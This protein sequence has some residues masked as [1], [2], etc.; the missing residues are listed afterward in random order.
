MNRISPHIRAFFFP[1]LFMVAYLFFW[2]APKIHLDDPWYE[3]YHQV[4]LA[5]TTQ[6]P[7][8][9]RKLLDRGGGALKELCGKYPYHAR[10][11]YLLG[12]YYDDAGNYDS[13]IVHAREAIRLGSG[14]TVD[15]VDG[16]ATELLIS[17]MSEK[18]SLNRN[19]PTARK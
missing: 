12:C 15:Q 6:D 13:A 19:E 4:N 1:S 18:A 11:H 14:A 2:N 5:M 16:L 10:V 7:V 9:K 8:M 17:A 3:A